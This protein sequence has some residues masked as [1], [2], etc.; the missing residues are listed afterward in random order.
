MTSPKSFF[1]SEDGRSLPE[2]AAAPPPGAA[3]LDDLAAA[4]RAP[5]RA[6]RLEPPPARTV[7]GAQVARFVERAVDRPLPRVARGDPGGVPDRVAVVA[8]LP[9]TRAVLADRERDRAA[10]ELARREVGERGRVIAR[11]V[12][13]PGRRVAVGPDDLIDLAV[14]AELVLL[15]RPC[16]VGV[17]RL[18]DVGEE[19]ARVVAA[20][21]AEGVGVRA[22]HV[23]PRVDHARLVVVV[24]VR[25]RRRERARALRLLQPVVRV[26]VL[27]REPPL[28]RVLRVRR[29]VAA[30]ARVA[31]RIDHADDVVAA[32]VR[33]GG[34]VILVL[35]GIARPRLAHRRGDP[36]DLVAH[37][38]LGE[39]ARGGDGGG[40]RADPALE[41]VL[42]VVA[43]LR[44]LARSRRALAGVLG[45]GRELRLDPVLDRRVGGVPGLLVPV[46]ALRQV[47][48]LVIPLGAGG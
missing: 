33:V 41:G 13:R 48:V 26:V 3:R 47:A 25:E 43:V 14:C 27:E 1:A 30:Q 38:A 44:D 8:D 20:D 22:G 45:R 24:V 18:L 31:A 19:I 23:A 9:V 15:Q 11:G 42:V 29:R 46:D 2:S 4:D 12:A 40:A 17:R 37:V 5:V 34:D 32:V 6:G 28:R 36:S 10:L 21:R 35:G 39:R 7:R 16:A